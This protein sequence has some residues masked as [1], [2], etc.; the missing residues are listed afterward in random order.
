M[1]ASG[2]MAI[3]SSQTFEYSCKDKSSFNCSFEGVKSGF[4]IDS[5]IASNKLIG[6]T[7]A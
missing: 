3:G 1:A 5:L 2:K 7:S 4:D 6:L